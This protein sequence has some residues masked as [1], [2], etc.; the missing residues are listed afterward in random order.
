MNDATPILIASDGSEAARQAVQQAA[1]LFGRRPVVV[2]TVWEPALAYQATV[3]PGVGADGIA[4][5]PVAVDTAEAKEIEDALAIRA[6]SVARD[7][8]ELAKSAGLRA[9]A[10]SVA[11]SGDVADAIL[12]LARERR[13]AAIVVGSRGVTG[14]RARL[15]G[16]TSSAVVKRSPCP[17][18]VVH[19]D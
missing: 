1:G 12:G 11:E 13:V 6:E 16:S 3:L 7:G 4:V 18:V 8:A 17:V 14:L 5:P 19:N 2:V 10:V 9:E 15:E